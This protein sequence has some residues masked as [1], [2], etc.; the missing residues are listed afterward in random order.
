[1]PPVNRPAAYYRATDLY[2]DPVAGVPITD[3]EDF[4]RAESNLRLAQCP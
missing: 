3:R 1:M 2:G 4:D